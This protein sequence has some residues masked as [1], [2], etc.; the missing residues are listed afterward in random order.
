VLDAGP[1]VALS[2]EV[3]TTP[4]R[5]GAE[6]PVR[7][8]PPSHGGRPP[9]PGGTQPWARMV[10]EWLAERT[11]E[12]T[13]R[14]VELGRSL[15]TF[16]GPNKVG[17]H[18]L[19]RYDSVSTAG[20][21]LSIGLVNVVRLV[22]AEPLPDRRRRLVDQ[23]LGYI[24]HITPPEVCESRQ[25]QPGQTRHRQHRGGLRVPSDRFALLLAPRT[26]RPF[27][28]PPGDGAR[29]GSPFMTPQPRLHD[30]DGA[31]GRSPHVREPSGESGTAARTGVISEPR[32][33][34]VCAMCRR[35]LVAGAG[36]TE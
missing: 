17:P 26:S 13:H 1:W 35:R 7:V 22:W 29:P 19:E 36:S 9:P 8:R 5:R 32:H 34:S 11:P 21:A 2:P 23:H 16:K 3:S 27:S 18:D 10:T 24:R 6:G 12:T 31:T 14:L 15:S 28:G 20:T 33:A 4:T 30:A 25:R